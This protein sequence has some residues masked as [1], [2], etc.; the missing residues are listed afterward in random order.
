[1]HETL[2]VNEVAER[3]RVSTDTIY[4]KIESGEIKAAK[5]FGMHR[6][7]VEEV[8]RLLTPDNN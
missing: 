2:T 8:E 5:V 7:P 6:I 3:L 1:M 4:R